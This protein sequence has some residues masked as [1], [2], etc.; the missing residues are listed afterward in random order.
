[1]TPLQG[2][3]RG[4][5]PTQAKSLGFVS[6]A[7]RADKFRKRSLLSGVVI[8]ASTDELPAPTKTRVSA[9]ANTSIASR[10][11]CKLCKR[12]EQSAQPSQ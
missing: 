9:G 7:L 11:L 3:R 8:E 1:V 10:T 12:Y 4:W 2:Y 6:K 5:G